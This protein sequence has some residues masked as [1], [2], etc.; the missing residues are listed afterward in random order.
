MVGVSD[1]RFAPNGAMTR[2]QLMTVLYRMADEPETAETTPFTDV[3]MD[4]Y[5][6]NAIA[7][8]AENGIAKGVTDTRFAPDAAVTREQMVTF[9]ARYAKYSG[10]DVQKTA[11]LTEFDD[12]GRISNYAK[13]PMAWAVE[14]GIL[15][16]MDGLLN[17]RGNATRAQIA[18]VLLRYS[19]I[20]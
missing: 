18:T 10:Q 9:L 13:E 15:T 5:Y 12:W 19:E 11:D 14:C 1:T 6:G 17:P 4:R 20:I 3:N 16:G 7:W 8:A 2:G